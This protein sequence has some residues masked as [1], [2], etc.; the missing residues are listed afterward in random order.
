MP[1]TRGRSGP[2]RKPTLLKIVT[3]NQGR[4]PL[5]KEEPE[6]AGGELVAPNWLNDPAKQKW[7]EVIEWC[8][9]ITLADGDM[10]ALYCDAF[11]R[12]L[13]A[14]KLAIL[15]PLAKNSDGRAVKNPAWTALNEAFQ[16]IRSAGSEL[17]LSP[18][19]RSG[20]GGRGGEAKKD[21][22]RSKYFA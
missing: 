13:Q 15:G 16:Q 14:Q 6:P 2:K 3:G 17:G 5:N 9:W 4:R 18:S 10:L 8:P 22:I 7:L 11:S 19:A 12:Y 20:I 21:G 1:G